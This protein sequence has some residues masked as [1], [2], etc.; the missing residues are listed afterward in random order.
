MIAD[1]LRDSY[2]RKQR[3]NN[4]SKIDIPRCKLISW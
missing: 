1:S 3:Q 2:F 4:C